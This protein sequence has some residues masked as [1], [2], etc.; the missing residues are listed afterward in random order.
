MKR[1]LSRATAMCLAWCLAAPTV[2]VERALLVGVSDYP[3]LPRRLWLH[4]PVND[5][6]LMRD[7]LLRRGYGA[8]NIRQ[9]SSRMG[10]SDEPTRAN[11]IAALSRLRGDL[12]PGDAVLLYFAGHGSQQPQ[13]ASHPGRPT[14]VDGLDEVF[15]PADV[16]KWNGDSTAVAIPNAILDDEIGEAIDTLVDRGATV[17]AIFDA[18]HAAGLA[19]GSS[20][21]VRAV[22]P[23]EFGLPT[24][25][26]SS[27]RVA[28]ADAG[29]HA[30]TD[31]RVLLFAARKHES[32][33]EEWLPKGAALGRNHMHGVFT[34]ALAQALTQGARDASQL[35][36]ALREIYARD[37]RVAPTPQ[38]LGVASLRLR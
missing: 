14:E 3:N 38:V 18:C 37:G 34:F 30:R 7:V 23:S 19:R 12:R 4:G 10:G 36:A 24:R 15:L 17:W 35:R 29:K 20:T 2:A 16:Q 31:G 5:V 25:L 13:P 11:I 21:H 6:A 27:P 32:T 26:N 33:R 8:E 28:S 22:A 9:L 1:L